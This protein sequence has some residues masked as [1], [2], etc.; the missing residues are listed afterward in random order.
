MTRRSDAAGNLEE[1]ETEEVVARNP[2]DGEVHTVP[3][4]PDQTETPEDLLDEAE[5]VLQQRKQEDAEF[6]ERKDRAAKELVERAVKLREEAD[7]MEHQASL[8]NPSLW[9]PEPL[10]P[11][12]GGAPAPAHVAKAKKKPIRPWKRNPKNK[13]K[14]AAQAKPGGKANVK[15]QPPPKGPTP[16][17]EAVLKALRKTNGVSQRELCTLNGWGYAG[18]GRVLEQLLADGQAHYTGVKRGTK[19]WHGRAK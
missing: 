9:S 2:Y 17:P 8:L 18:T 15:R 1:N 5:R 12:A 10:L 4:V 13:T 19:W 7:K 16:G 6:T 11:C 3:A 14:R